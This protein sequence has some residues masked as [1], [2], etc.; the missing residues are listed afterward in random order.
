MKTIICIF[1]LSTVSLL[2]ISQEKSGNDCPMDDEKVKA[3]KVAFIT[4]KLDLTVKEAQAFWPIYNEFTNKMDVLF[5]EEHKIAKEL[6]KNMATL[7]DKELT[8]KIDRVI[9]IKEEKADLEQ[10]YHIKYKSVLPIKKVALL[11]QADR[12]FRKYLL[13]KYKDHP[14]DKDPN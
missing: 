7:S 6:K 14:C 11:Y 2:A 5:K 12:D 1:L 8:E 3:E 4:E 9:A 10:S 13:Q